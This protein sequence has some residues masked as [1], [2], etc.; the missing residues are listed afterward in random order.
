[1]MGRRP[2]RGR[3][4]D[5]D[6]PGGGAV[7]HQTAF[8]IF[9]PDAAW[10]TGAWDGHARAAPHDPAVCRSGYVAAAMRSPPGISSGTLP[11]SCLS[12]EDRTPGAR[13]NLEALTSI[14]GHEFVR[15]TGVVTDG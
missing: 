11:V 7:A 6:H 1:M 14:H 2:Q 13:S 4:H 5:A 3:G 12:S 8:V 10:G 15:C 9:M